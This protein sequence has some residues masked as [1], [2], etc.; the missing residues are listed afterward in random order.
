MVS[1]FIRHTLDV[2]V[3]RI[4][5]GFHDT[6][7]ISVLLPPGSTPLQVKAVGGGGSP[8]Y[9]CGVAVQLSTLATC[10]EPFLACLLA[11]NTV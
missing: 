8:S 1:S 2:L 7:L 10:L 5:A 9:V 3:L 6:S 4:R 11:S